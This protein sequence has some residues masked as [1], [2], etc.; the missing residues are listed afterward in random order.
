[1]KTSFYSF[2]FAQQAYFNW[3]FIPSRGTLNYFDIFV[4]S[5]S[6]FANGQQRIFFPRFEWFQKSK[7]DR[8]QISFFPDYSGR[9]RIWKGTRDELR[10]TRCWV[11]LSTVSTGASHTKQSHIRNKTIC[12]K[13]PALTLWTFPL[14]VDTKQ[15]MCHTP[16]VSRSINYKIMHTL[17]TRI[18]SLKYQEMVIIVCTL[19]KIKIRKVWH[20]RWW[21]LRSIQ[22][23][24]GRD[25]LIQGSG[26]LHSKR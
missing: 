8:D 5:R 6:T 15:C 21:N 17:S 18:F 3:Y 12:A 23:S 16:R 26:H 13:G 7:S 22:R 10:S 20:I 4:C 14:T 19:S 24:R 11:T 2:F 9:N 1:M 25:V